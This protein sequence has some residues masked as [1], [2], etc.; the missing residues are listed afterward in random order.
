MRGSEPMPSRT[1]SMS[2]PK[3]SARLAN[4]FMKLILVASMALAAYLVSSAERTSITIMR[5]RL[6]VKGSYS[7][8]IISV[9]RAESV[10][11]ITRSGRMKSAM[12]A[13]SLRNS[14]FETVSNSTLRLARRQRRFHRLAHLVGGAHRHGRLGDHDLVLAHVLADGARHRQHIAQVR[15]TILIGRRAHRNQLELSVPHAFRGTGGEAQTT[16]I[17]I[18]LDHRI[19]AGLMDGHLAPLQHGGL[20]FVDVHAHHMVAGIRQTRARHQAHVAR[21]KNRNPHA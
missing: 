11:T 5:S 7:E 17:E 4:S 8:R 10:P 9:A 21:A 13:P 16:R 18:A 20:A 19:E 14:G 15:R 1:S 3:C 12:A 6:C 2:A